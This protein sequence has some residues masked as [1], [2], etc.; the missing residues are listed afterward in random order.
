VVVL[1]FY[2]VDGQL[3][4]SE[5]GLSGVFGRMVNVSGD[6][7]R[8]VA[9]VQISSVFEHSAL[10]LASDLTDVIL[11]IL[12]DRHGQVHWPMSQSNLPKAGGAVGADR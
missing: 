7:A 8:Y 3:A 6:P 2:I 4:L 9:Q 10:V 5:R 1:G 12:P 11:A